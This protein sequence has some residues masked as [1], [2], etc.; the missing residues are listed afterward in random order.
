[1]KKTACLA[2]ALIISTPAL[3]APPVTGKWVTTEKDSIVEITPCG[4]ALCGKIIR[5][6]R[7]NPKGPTV[8]ANN[9]NPAMRNRPIQGLT[10]LSGFADN[11]KNW[12]GS[13]YDPRRGKSFKSYLTR[14]AGGNLEVKGCIAFMCQSFIW[15]PAG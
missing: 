10:I 14:V 7:P 11:G 8:D 15:T 5:I 6:L 2:L 3:A 9:P 1:M 4:T 12:L 13:I